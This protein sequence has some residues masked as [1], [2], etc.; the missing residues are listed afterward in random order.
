MRQRCSILIVTCS[1]SRNTAGRRLLLALHALCHR[2]ARPARHRMFSLMILHDHGSE[3]VLCCVRTGERA[4]PARAP[5]APIYCASCTGLSPAIRA[6]TRPSAALLFAHDGCRTF[7]VH[8]R[9]RHAMFQLSYADL[10]P[11]QDWIRRFAF[12]L[13]HRDRA[14]CG[15][16]ATIS[17]S[18]PPDYSNHRFGDAVSFECWPPPPPEA[19]C[20]SRHRLFC[21]F[22]Q[23]THGR[24]RRQQLC[25]AVTPTPH[26]RYRCASF[27][28]GGT[29][30]PTRLPSTSPNTAPQADQR[31]RRCS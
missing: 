19:I 7:S 17:A 14:L 15:P 18:M 5:P 23:S 10:G 1:C 9:R 3:H 30:N 11:L 4:V 27:Q 21:V 13:Q 26:H 2:A 25:V 12:L 24:L 31:Q 8:A 20:P 29:R 6:G 22:A 28:P 16:G